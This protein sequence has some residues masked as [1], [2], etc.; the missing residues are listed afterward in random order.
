LILRP[1]WLFGKQGD[2]FPKKILRQAE[3]GKAFQ[4]V[5]DQF[6]SPTFTW[7]LAGAVSEIIDILTSRGVEKANQIYHLT[8]DGTVSRYEFAR[9]ILRKRN[10]R[11]ELVSPIS[12]DMILSGAARPRN[13]ALSTEKIKSQLGIRLRSWEEALEAYLQED[14][15]SVHR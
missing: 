8:N 11:P 3:A 9:T 14:L 12:S 1:S 7:D 6:G 4:V 10:L 15:A 2:N 5:S 13:S